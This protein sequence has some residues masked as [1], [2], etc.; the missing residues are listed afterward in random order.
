MT[1]SMRAWL[2]NGI[3][4]AVFVDCGVVVGVWGGWLVWP[5]TGSAV[6]VGGSEVAGEI[7][8]MFRREWGTAFA[9]TGNEG[10]RGV[11]PISSSDSPK[12]SRANLSRISPGSARAAL[13]N[14]IRPKPS[15]IIIET[16]VKKAYFVRFFMKRLLN[17]TAR[18]A[19]HE[20]RLID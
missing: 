18:S 16:A 1:P 12:G 20:L 13:G 5:E 15:K 19:R 3:A 8:G 4:V 7:V 17:L 10:G 2:G 9:G 6:D 14:N 11:V